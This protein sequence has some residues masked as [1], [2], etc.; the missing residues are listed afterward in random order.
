MTKHTFNYIIGELRPH[1]QKE[2]TQM[3][4]SI[5]PDQRI[6]IT[7]WKLATNIDYRTLAE[8]F[9]VGKSTVCTIFLETINFIGMHLKS[10]HIALPR[11]QRLEVL[12][13]VFMLN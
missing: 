8:L 1:I 5:P 13:I 6:A 7:L 4:R 2:D 3:R 10:R 12:Q 11:G 9:G